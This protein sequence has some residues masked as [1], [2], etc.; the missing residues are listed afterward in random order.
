MLN[1]TISWSGGKDSAFALY[2]I[3]SD[4]R[5]KVTGLHT[6]IDEGSRRVG[7]HGVRE[8]IIDFQAKSLGL[9]ITKLYTS[10]DAGKSNYESVIRPF[11][12]KCVSD[13]VG[14]VVFGDIFLDDL[15]AYR[16]Q[17][18]DGL[19]IIPLF[20]LWKIDSRKIYSDFVGAG[21]KAAIC[22]ASAELFSEQQL[23]VTLESTT[24]RTFTK[25]IDV[26]GENGEFHTLV[27]DGP[28]FKKPLMLRR[29]EVVKKWYEYRTKTAAGEIEMM[30]T[31][32]LFQEF[33]LLNDS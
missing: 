29:G 5:Y 8:E 4:D 28:I 33:F 31:L 14:S 32:F 13:S 27:Y 2:K 12:E 24:P 21:F 11:Y 23:G 1:A 6:L 26:C 9:P 22:S 20:P 7:L 30:K 25:G 18:M 3:L 10:T 15:R 16:E 19:N 17:L